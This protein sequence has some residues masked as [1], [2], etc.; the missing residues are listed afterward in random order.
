M[1]I[2]VKIVLVKAYNFISKVKRYYTIVYRAYL[3]IIIKIP[4]F[5]KEIALQMAFK[6]INDFIKL[7]SLV[8]TLL[9]YSA[10]PCIIE[11]NPLSP[12]LA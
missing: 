4:G 6:A 10:Y 1:G 7:N 11:N 3:I 2:K 12:G 5:I 8:F 9:V